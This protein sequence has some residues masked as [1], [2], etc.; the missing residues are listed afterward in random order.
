MPS[1]SVHGVFPDYKLLIKTSLTYLKI[2]YDDLAVELTD[3]N[4]TPDEKKGTLCVLL[5]VGD[6]THIP[7]IKANRATVGL[8][9]HFFSGTES[10]EY[11][12]VRVH[13]TECE[14]EISHEEYI[15]QSTEIRRFFE[16]NIIGSIADQFKLYMG[17]I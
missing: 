9:Y 2:E 8:F 7:G 6:L 14:E 12:L 16:K 17:P 1:E 13:D 11:K 10:K 3:L 4:W 15:E 5:E